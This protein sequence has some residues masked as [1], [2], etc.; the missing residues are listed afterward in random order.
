MDDPEHLR[1]AYCMYTSELRN[2]D[3]H[4]LCFTAYM[5]DNLE[6]NGHIT[7]MRNIKT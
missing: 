1:E 6:T 5:K 4:N 7:E 3:L 2:E